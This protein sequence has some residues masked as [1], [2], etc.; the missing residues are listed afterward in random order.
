MIIRAINVLITIALCTL[1]TM[2]ASNK[3]CF[4]PLPQAGGGGGVLCCARFISN[5]KV[6]L[7]LKKK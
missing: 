1:L 5:K 2:F 6:F 7:L 4:E 3:T